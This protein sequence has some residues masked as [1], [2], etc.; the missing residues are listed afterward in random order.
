MIYYSFYRQKWCFVSVFYCQLITSW[1][2]YASIKM[3]FV[4]TCIFSDHQRWWSFLW[5]MYIQCVSVYIMCESVRWEWWKNWILWMVKQSS[6]LNFGVC[7]CYYSYT[8]VIIW[9]KLISPDQ[10]IFL[11]FLVRESTSDCTLWCRNHTYSGNGS[12]KGWKSERVI[13]KHKRTEFLSRPGAK[14]SQGNIW[15]SPRSESPLLKSP[16]KG[17]YCCLLLSLLFSD[18]L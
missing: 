18:C 6:I 15:E 7:S 1:A 10:L 5:M 12:L 13:M 17:I 11:I 3:L 4:K 2:K 16:L 8:V 14:H 9:W